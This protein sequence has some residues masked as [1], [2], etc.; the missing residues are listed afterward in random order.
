MGSKI[1]TRFQ[2]ISAE[3]DMGGGGGG[4]GGGSISFAESLSRCLLLGGVALCLLKNS[5]IMYPGEGG[6]GKERVEGGR[7]GEGEGREG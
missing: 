1:L 6:E 7:G 3:I 4:G 5:C 2:T